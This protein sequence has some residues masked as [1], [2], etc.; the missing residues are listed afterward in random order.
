MIFRKLK[1]FVNLKK[2]T[3][4]DKEKKISSKSNFGKKIRSPVISDEA[5]NGS[6]ANIPSIYKW[7]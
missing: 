4:Y 3:D 5:M 7:N 1:L 2:K 6:K